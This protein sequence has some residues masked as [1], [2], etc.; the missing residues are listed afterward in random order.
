MLTTLFFC[1]RA[2]RHPLISPPGLN[3]LYLIGEQVFLSL[4][5][6]VDFSEVPLGIDR[7]KET[8]PREIR[9]GI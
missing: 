5:T 9:V 7:F 3:R 4:P 2:R 6:S 1:N 8:H